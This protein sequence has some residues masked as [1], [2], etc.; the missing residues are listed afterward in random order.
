MSAAFRALLLALVPSVAFA[1]SAQPAPAAPGA[2]LAQQDRPLSE[3]VMK[4]RD[5]FKRPLIRPENLVPK[6][7]LERFAV[8]QYKLIGVLTGPSRMRGVLQD[9]EGKTHIISERMK[10]GLKQGTIVKIQS[11][12]IKVREKVANIFGQLENVDTEIPLQEKGAKITSTVSTAG[13]PTSFEGAG[14]PMTPQPPQTGG[15]PGMEMSEPKFTVPN[16]T[17]AAPP[18]ARDN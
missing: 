7:E 12:R 15:G 16:G 9:P 1:Q 11:R 4:L 17:G 8:D 13:G 3:E 18:G 10:I 2:Q 6:T 5:P 14:V